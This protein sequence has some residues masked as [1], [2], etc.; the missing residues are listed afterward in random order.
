MKTATL[1]KTKTGEKDLAVEVFIL[2]LSEP[3]LIFLDHNASS[4]H[5]RLFVLLRLGEK[6]KREQGVERDRG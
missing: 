4:K 3:F 2:H 5:P 6:G 1:N